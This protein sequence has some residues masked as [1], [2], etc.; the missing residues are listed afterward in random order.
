[1]KQLISRLAKRREPPLRNQGDAARD[2]GEWALA[3]NLYS[4]HLQK[5]PEDFA[6]WVQLGHAK[7]ESG[8][9]KGAR[10]AYEKA[11]ELRPQD[12]DL[13]LNMGRLLRLQGKVADAVK[14]FRQSHT[15]DQNR[16]A[17]DELNRTLGLLPIDVAEGLSAMSESEK[18]QKVLLSGFFDPAWYLDRYP[19][20][21]P[22]YGGPLQHFVEHGGYEWRSPGPRFDTEWYL[23][24]N[25]DLIP[26][27]EARIVNPLLHFL[28]HG[29][30]EGRRPTPPTPTVFATT[31]V[32]VDDIVDIEPLIYSREKIHRLKSLPVVDSLPKTKSFALFGRAFESIQKPYDYVITIPWLVHGGA[33]L[34]ALHMARAI[35]T[36]CGKRAVLVVAVDF[37][38]KEALDWLPPGVDFL[39]LQSEHET[40]LA[41][42]STEAILYLLQALQPRCVINVNS[43]ATWEVFRLYGRGLSRSMRL[44][45][46]AFCRDY[47]QH[48]LPA[49]YADTH[50][51]DA[52][53]ILSGLISDNALFFETLR[54]HF[55][56][57]ESLKTRFIA[58]YNPAPEA[59]TRAAPQEYA[60]SFDLTPEKKFRVLWASRLTRQK[61]LDLLQR[62]ASSAP[63]ISIDVWGRGE[64]EGPLRDCSERTA[65]LT[66]CGSYGSFSEL[67]V[68][69]YNA[70]L[71]TSRWDGIPNVLLEAAAADLPIVS[72]DVGGI[73]ELVD[74]ATGWLIA[75]LEDPAP[76]VAALRKIRDDPETVGERTRGM[77]ERLAS[78]HCWDSFLSRI[79]SAGI[80][81]VET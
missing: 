9:L 1:M 42:E 52:L 32:L 24:Q 61:N 34:M 2:A 19:D 80:V 47:N 55:R 20:L 30:R 77:R 7:K 29:A 33:E 41:D 59:I 45:G 4:E 28:E 76:Y 18:L 68:E 23:F 22:A 60:Y 53:P 31:Q 10:S 63:D 64:G 8:D 12:A 25:P 54:K 65:N 26:G 51:R 16:D 62:I 69:D 15:L 36:L 78:R 11:M 40:C 43:M 50:V 3:A 21:D 37:P 17:L 44:Y 67:P 27:V 14:H 75:D 39:M 5:N 38:R 79:V 72:S 48:D 73:S 71:Y 35:A 74:N 66:V 58:L 46:C 6:I 81:E 56:I 49:G 57:P 70:F 13:L